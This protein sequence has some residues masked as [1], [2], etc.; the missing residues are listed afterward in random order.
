MRNLLRVFLLACA[1]GVPIW[2]AQFSVKTLQEEG[3]LFGSEGNLSYSWL[4]AV[5]GVVAVALI[6]VLIFV[7]LFSA[8]FPSEEDGKEDVN[9][10]YWKYSKSKKTTYKFR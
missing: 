5:V 7:S 2:F 4:M 3:F 10:E 9:K 6:S 8:T 1:V